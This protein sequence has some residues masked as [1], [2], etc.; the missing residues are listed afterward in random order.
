MINYCVNRQIFCLFFCLGLFAGCLDDFSTESDSDPATNH[1]DGLAEQ[2]GIKVYTLPAPLQAATLIKNLNMNYSEELMIP[3]SSS[4]ARI[5]SSPLKAIYLGM[6]GIDLGYATLFDDHQ[7]A[8]Y[9]LDHM[10]KIS[11]DLD[12][13][14]GFN[15]TLI[16]RYEHNRDNKDSLYQIILSSFNDVNRYLE[17]NNRH[18]VGLLLTAGVLIEG[19]HLSGQS[20][21]RKYNDHLNRAVKQHYTFL[22]NWLELIAPYR[23]QE[24]IQ[25]L[26]LPFDELKA[27]ME[28]L[29]DD[30]QR[31]SEPQLESIR[32]TVSRIRQQIIG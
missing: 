32:E 1:Q 18:D 8:I 11:D 21:S 26:A 4:N 7:R 17:E 23:K 19:L 9:Y 28:G 2:E 10:Q 13:V 25:K 27:A 15:P 3:L 22:N 12:I 14:T 29:K 31:I 16:H 20:I 30:E 24:E 6:Y 5:A